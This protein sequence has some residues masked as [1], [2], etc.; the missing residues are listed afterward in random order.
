MMALKSPQISQLLIL[1]LL[2]S[3]R[4]CALINLTNES[5]PMKDVNGIFFS[6]ND[7]GGALFMVGNTVHNGVFTNTD[8]TS[9]TGRQSLTSK[10]S[11]AL[12]GLIWKCAVA[13]KANNNYLCTGS[14]PTQGKV[15]YITLDPTSN[16]APTVINSEVNNS[17]VFVAVQC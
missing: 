6:G 5:V 10:S 11:T 16:T 4:V 7:N 15:V 8:Y 3:L 17:Y 13:S 9:A 14:H 12:S 2:A 1:C